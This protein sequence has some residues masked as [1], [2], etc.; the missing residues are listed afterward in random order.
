[1]RVRRFDEAGAFLR[2]KKRVRERDRFDVLHARIFTEL[3]VDVEEHRHVHLADER[4]QVSA[5]NET[6]RRVLPVRGGSSVA[7]RSKS[8]GSC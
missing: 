6:D 8:T 4:S 2:L 3:G 5:R 1:M 7:L